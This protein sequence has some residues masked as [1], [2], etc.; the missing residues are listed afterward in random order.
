MKLS[1]KWC[2]D[3]KLKMF[4]YKPIE[5][6]DYILYNALLRIETISTY[7]ITEHERSYLGLPIFTKQKRYHTNF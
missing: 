5:T 1:L 2:I 4:F 7:M 6:I 3:Q